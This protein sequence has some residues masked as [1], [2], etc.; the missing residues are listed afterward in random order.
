MRRHLTIRIEMSPRDTDSAIPSLEDR[1]VRK[2][3]IGA[4]FDFGDS[5]QGEV[6][7]PDFGRRGA[8]FER[9]NVQIAGTLAA[10]WLV[11]LA[12]DEFLPD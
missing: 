4:P 12:H 1:S 5:G 7:F 11:R 2:S 3:H 9:D 10:G 6:G 8:G